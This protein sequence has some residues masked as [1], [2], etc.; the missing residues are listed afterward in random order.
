[1]QIDPYVF[2]DE[3]VSDE[4]REFNAELQNLLRAMPATSSLPPDETRRARREG[5]GVFPPP[6]YSEHARDVVIDGPAGD[7]TLRIHDVPDPKGVYVHVHGGGWVLGAADLSDVSNEVMAEVAQVSVVSIDYRLAP[8]NKFPAGFDDCVAGA[9]WVIENAM[10]QFGTDRLTIGGESAGANLAAA[11]LLATRDAGYSG[12]L[13]ANLVYGSYLPTGSP[14]VHEWDT[15][16]LVLDPDTMF[17]FGNNYFGNVDVE[18]R[19]PRLSPLY[20]S[21]T[22]MPPAL[23]TVGTLDPLLDDTLFMAMRWLAAGCDPELKIY[24]GGIHAFDAFPISIGI[25][26]RARMHAFIRDAVV[27]SSGEIE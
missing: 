5:R 17:W 16:G 15:T 18:F 3:A 14:S 13:G 1:M 8:E 19:D 24:P 10:T 20:G 27:E 21:L 22:G 4:T 26:A 2:T 25:E 23:F 6:I 9:T 11:T 12:W 7:L